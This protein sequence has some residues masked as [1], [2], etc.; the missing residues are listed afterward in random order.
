VNDILQAQNP[1][2]K[3]FSVRRKRN[4]D[5]NIDFP[6]KDEY[7]V[8][9]VSKEAI[10]QIITN[11]FTKVF[12][13]NPVPDD[14][15]WKEYWALVDEVFMLL[16][17]KTRECAVYE[18]PTLE[19]IEDIVD[20]LK[21]TKATYGPLTIDLVKLAGKKITALIHRCILKCVKLNTLPEALRIEKITILLK[22][23]GVIDNINDYRGIFLRNIILSIFQKW[24]YSK[25]AGVVD[26]NGSEYA[27]GGR[28]DRSG[29]EALL[30]VKLVQDYSKWTKRQ[31]II[32]F[33]DVEKFFDSMNFKKAMIEVYQSGVRGRHWQCYKT[34][35]EKKTCIPHNHQ[36]NVQK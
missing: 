8:V 21:I 32:K 16:D 19:E 29:T 33:L 7:G 24:L 1:H 17:Q 23:N 6:L 20:A 25:N 27:C 15:K 22:S 5:N 35:N 10:D 4:A 2:S 9:Q 13:Q 34:I 18:E 31:I 3:V 30:I 28:K 12:A 14:E 11:H 26:K 36:E